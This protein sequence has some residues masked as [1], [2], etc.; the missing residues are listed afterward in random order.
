M[1]EVDFCSVLKTIQEKSR[2]FDFLIDLIDITKF[3]EMKRKY[4]SLLFNKTFIFFLYVE[5]KNV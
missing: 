3:S 2:L 1:D 5:G 4:L